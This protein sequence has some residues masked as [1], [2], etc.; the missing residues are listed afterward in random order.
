MKKRPKPIPIR[1]DHF[2]GVRVG[3]DSTKSI[4]AE[5]RKRINPARLITIAFLKKS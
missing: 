3:V 4:E 1:V 5:A 2:K